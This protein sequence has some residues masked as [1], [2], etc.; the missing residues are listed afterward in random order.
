MNKPNEKYAYHGS[1]NFLGLETIVPKKHVRSRKDEQGNLKVI[2]DE[3]SFHA[4]PYRWIALAYTL[5][6]KH[7]KLDGEI[8]S[9]NMGVDLYD[10]EEELKIFGIESLEKSLE[11]LYGDGGY[12]FVFDKGKFF[13]TQGLG[14]LEIITKES[15]KPIRVERIDHPVSELK[16]LGI[17]FKFIDLSKP[18]NERSR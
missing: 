16:K 6:R 9:Y 15:L 1:K 12:L 2:F 5:D 11:K 17:S 13:H 7:F 3:I 10:H 18:E 8:V 14:N 4:T